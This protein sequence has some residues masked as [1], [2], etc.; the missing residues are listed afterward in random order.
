MD[1][2]GTHL[3]RGARRIAPG[4]ARPGQAFQFLLGRIA[5]GHR[6]DRVLVAQLVK[7]EVAHGGDVSR[8][9]DGIGPVGEQARHLVRGLEVALGVG[10]KPVAG[11]K[12]GAVLADAGEHVLQGPAGGAVGVHVIGGDEGHAARPGKLGEG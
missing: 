12:D 11:L 3:F 6:V 9:G 8:A 4:G 2:L 10:V 7:G 1:D 5:R